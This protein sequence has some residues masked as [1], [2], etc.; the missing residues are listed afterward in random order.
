MLLVKVTVRPETGFP[1]TSTRWATAVVIECGAAR[2]GGGPA[3]DN[4]RRCGRGQPERRRRVALAAGPPRHPGGGGGGGPE[5]ADGVDGEEGRV[6]GGRGPGRG[7]RRAGGERRSAERRPA[8]EGGQL[9]RGRGEAAGGVAE[10]VVGALAGDP[11]GRRG[12][13]EVGGGIVDAGEAGVGAPEP[14]PPHRVGADVEGA[15]V[16]RPHL[17]RRVECAPGDDRGA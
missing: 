4:R 12:V 5:P 9:Q 10:D 14:L 6:V 3:G 8:V 2:I 7:D 1:A 16:E 13:V 11:E 17:E 15:V